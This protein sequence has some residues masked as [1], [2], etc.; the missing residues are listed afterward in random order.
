MIVINFSDGGHGPIA[1]AGASQEMYIK[2]DN[3][4][5]NNNIEMTVPAQDTM[6]V[7]VPAGYGAGSFV[8]V[9]HPVSGE[10]VTVTI[11]EGM[12]EGMQFQVALPVATTSTYYAESESYAAV[13]DYDS[14]FT[15]E[16]GVEETNQSEYVAA[17][18]ETDPALVMDPWMEG[19]EEAIVS[20]VNGAIIPND[21]SLAEGEI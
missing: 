7:T 5:T 6:M 11:P 10:T 12:M 1:A 21:A 4:A 9:I 17:V 14:A 19:T 16:E 18:D 15:T 13:Q 2:D 3:N 20:T 8:E